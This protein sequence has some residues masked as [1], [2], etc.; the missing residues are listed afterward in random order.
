MSQHDP[1]GR[2]LAHG[3]DGS[4]V[5][6]DQFDWAKIEPESDLVGMD[7]ESVD[8]AIVVMRSLLQW[9]WKNGMNNPEGLQLRA[10]IVCWLFLKEL[11]P[12]QLSELARGFGK[13]KQS[14]GR[15]VDDFKVHFPK[16][17]SPH[18]RPLRDE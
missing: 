1:A 13:K 10:M 5:H 11:R 2:E 14:V 6:V 18:M 9:V 15:H 3:E 12:M 4:L 17:R 7:Q 8:R 16:F